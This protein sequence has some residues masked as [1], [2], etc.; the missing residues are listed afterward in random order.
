M[1]KHRGEDLY[2]Y[3]ALRRIYLLQRPFWAVTDRMY[4][5]DRARRD[6]I[7]QFLGKRRRY[8]PSLVNGSRRYDEYGCSL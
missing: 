7:H 3:R 8:A 6:R 4:E 1:P 5:G 2:T